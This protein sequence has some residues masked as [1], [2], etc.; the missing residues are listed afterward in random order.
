MSM[1]A[2]CR[3]LPLFTIVAAVPVLL[4]AGDMEHIRISEDGRWFERAESGRVFRPHGFNY[5]HDVAGRLIEDYWNDEWASVVH[6]FQEM[7]RLGANVV[8]VH[9]QFGQFM[10]APDKPREAPLRRLKQLLALAEQ[11]GLY[12]DLTGLGCY[13]KSD[14]PKWYDRLSE[15][16]RWKAQA[17]FWAAV[18]SCCRESPAVFCYDLM[19]E[20]VVPGNKR[21]SDWLGP[22][23]GKKHFVQFITR[24]AQG[25][26][27]HEIARAWIRTLVRSIRREDPQRLVTVGLVP[28]SVPRPGKPTSGFT[29]ARIAGELDFLSLHIYPEKEKLN[30]AASIVHELAALGK[31][32]VIE[33]FFPLK[34]GIDEL[35]EFVED[36]RPEVQGWISFYWGKTLEEYQAGT[37]IRDAIMSQWLTTFRDRVLRSPPA[38]YVLVLGTAQDGGLP[39][40]ACGGAN[41]RA[42]RR[43]ARLAR[44]VASL[45]LVDPRPTNSPSSGHA[46]TDPAGPRQW[47]FDATPDLRAQHVTAMKMTGSPLPTTSRPPLFTGVFLTHA[48]TGHYLGLAQFGRPAY[49]AHGQPVYASQRMCRFLDDNG[50]WS[51][52][53]KNGNLVLHPVEPQHRIELGNELFVTP[54]RVPHRAEFTDTYGYVISGPSRKLLY[55]PDID[56]WER[57]DAA[58]EDWIER[59]DDALVDGTFFADGEVPGRKMSEI[60][61]PFVVETME[62]LARLP[63]RERRKVWFTHLNHTNP[64]NDPNSE[65]SRRVRRSGMHVARDG[66]RFRLSH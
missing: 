5:D 7:K 60:P 55:I 24:S 29:P 4:Y 54:I 64:L 35:Q 57:W 65:A 34:C 9:L 11:T 1:T 59:V 28:W 42:A 23:L 36:V 44:R 40:L 22:A 18:A 20:P 50:P 47:L 56:K 38:P 63:A 6:D 33:E 62:R 66:M 26:P 39:Q 46:E 43:D 2:H 25:R 21:R 15:R 52:L 53:V 45:L 27:R 8:R 13:H 48:H 41:C 61:H 3:V 14:V 31:P 16:E 12:L 51:L 10:D 58:I 30:E 37:T 32:L 49:N 17:A 19:N